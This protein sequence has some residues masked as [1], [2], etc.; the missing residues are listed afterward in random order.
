MSDETL[1]NRQSRL[2]ELFKSAPIVKYFGMVLTY[3]EERQAVVTLPFNPNLDHAL[4]Q[5]H[6]GALATLLD[7]AGW[8]TVA[9]HFDHWIAT[10]E[11]QT[12]LLEPTEK[13]DL[14]AIGKI[15]R[16]GKRIVVGEMTVSNLKGQLIAVGSGSFTV[17][18]VPFK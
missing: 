16:P 8:F 10:V 13:E 2:I 12:R 18:S 11:F 6:G 4:H 17:T 9:P 1:K 7:T 5:I 15:I 14:V 3:N